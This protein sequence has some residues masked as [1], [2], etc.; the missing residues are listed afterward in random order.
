[1]STWKIITLAAALESG[2]SPNDIVDGSSP[3]EFGPQWGKTQNAE[4][5]TG[6]MTLRAAT[7]HSVNCAFARTELAVGLPRVIDTAHKMG[8]TQKTLKPILTL[9][10]GTVESTAL[11]MATVTATIAASGVHHPPTFVKKIIGPDGEVVFDDR[12][13][14]P[15][16]VISENAATCEMDLL[17]GVV[18]SGTGTGGRLASHTNFGKTGTTDS[19]ADAN[20]LGGTPQLVTFIW[21]G[22]ITARVPGAGFGGQIPAH[23]FKLYMEPALDGLPDV[24]LPPPGPFCARPAAFITPGGRVATLN[25]LLPGQSTVPTQAPPTVVINNPTT[26]PTLLPTTTTTP[27]TT[28]TH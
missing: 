18:T 24:H 25:G 14:Q 23:I 6:P 16:Q 1:V 19:K 10:L 28:T 15:K 5:G 27:P 20:F 3:C 13:L 12:D 26:L 8:I 22:N 2:F 11:E 21:H 7:A 4:G 17:R 9:T